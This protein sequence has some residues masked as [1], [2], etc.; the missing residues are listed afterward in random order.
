MPDSK[1]SILKLLPLGISRQK[2]VDYKQ[3]LIPPEKIWSLK[4]GLDDSSP[5]LLKEATLSDKP[6]FIMTQMVSK[7]KFSL[8]QLYTYA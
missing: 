7:R 2:H 1:P 3:L 5:M 8:W 6:V 4:L